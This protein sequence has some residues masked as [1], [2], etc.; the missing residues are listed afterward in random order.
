MPVVYVFVRHMAI[1]AFSIHNPWRTTS[2]IVD[3][4]R[5][6]IGS[7]LSDLWLKPFSSAFNQGNS[8][9]HT[10]I[11]RSAFVASD[12]RTELENTGSLLHEIYSAGCDYGPVH[13]Q[14]PCGLRPFGVPPGGW[15]H[16]VRVRIIH[17]A[18]TQQSAAVLQE[19]L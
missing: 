3:P 17:A 16:S 19:H 8:D 7:H 12:S 11:H 15:T 1:S 5:D 10:R 2:A 14:T 9:E 4:T 13:P 18:E 6:S